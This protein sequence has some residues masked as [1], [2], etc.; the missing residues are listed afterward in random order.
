V[1]RAGDASRTAALGALLAVTIWGASFAAT[2]RLL[3]EVSPGTVL[4][5]RTVLATLF[6]GGGL[7]LRGRLRLFPARDWARLV[8]LSLLGLVLTQL[9]QAYA[10]RHSSSANTAWLVALGPVVTALLAAWLIGERLDGRIA[11]LALAFGGGFLV[12]SGGRSPGAALALPST[13]GDGLTLVSTVTWALYTVQGRGFAAGRP[14]RLITAHLLAI[15]ALFY[16]PVFLLEGGA[17]QLPRLSGTG[18][19]CLGYLGIGCSGLGFMLYGAALEHMDA[20]QVAA[21]IYLEPLIA[22]AIGAT[23]MGEALTAATLAG[24]AAILVGVYL[25]T[26]PQP[27]PAVVGG[28]GVPPD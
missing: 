15:A 3:V 8:S 25:V 16:L 5:G 19:L 27:E 13:R 10:L 24:G 18:W 2:K 20:A 14:P 9:L 11:G 4:L 21:F 7:A 12:V 28:V 6:I 23:V 26:R 22:Q 1:T 17:T